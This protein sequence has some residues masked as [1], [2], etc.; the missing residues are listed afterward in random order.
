[1]N[2]SCLTFRRCS[3]IGQILSIVCLFLYCVGAALVAIAVSTP[4]WLVYDIGE[5]HQVSEIETFDTVGIAYW[6]DTSMPY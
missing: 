2:S 1:M 6:I 3:I 5:M 4:N